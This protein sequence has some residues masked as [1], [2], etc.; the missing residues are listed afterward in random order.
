MWN[1]ASKEMKLLGAPSGLGVGVNFQFW[2]GCWSTSEQRKGER[3]M[4]AQKPVWDFKLPHDAIA[5]KQEKYQRLG[6]MSNPFPSVGAASENPSYPPLSTVDQDLR[7]IIRHFA[8]TNASQMAVIIGNYG[9]GKTHTLRLIQE[10]LR[11]L[12][13]ALNPKIVYLSSAGYEAYSLLR[14]VLDQFGR[15]EITKIV[16]KLLLD[17]IQANLE[18]QKHQ[19]FRA[20][21]FAEKE[22]AR[23]EQALQN[24]LF[25]SEEEQQSIPTGLKSEDFT[26]YRL[27]LRKY[28]QLGFSIA[29]LRGYAIR[30]LTQHFEC[31]AF[32]AA[33]LFDATDDDLL[34]SRQPGIA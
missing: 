17:D 10:H 33:E 6:L 26:D 7:N 11:G 8:E 32:I 27:F 15:D 19:W 18:L 4:V 21:F 5:R 3:V 12:S 34:R 2:Q 31:S 9:T 30:F 25:Q 28:N 16:W 29:Q 14:G 20:T 22:R 13:I 24:S 1:S 23:V